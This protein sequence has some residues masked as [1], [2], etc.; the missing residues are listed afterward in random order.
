[1]KIQIFSLVKKIIT[2]FRLKFQKGQVC[3]RFFRREGVL[4]LT[5][6]PSPPPPIARRISSQVT[7]IGIY[8]HRKLYMLV[9]KFQNE[10]LKLILNRKYSHVTV[11]QSSRQNHLLSSFLWTE[12]NW[13][14]LKSKKISFI[15]WWVFIKVR[16]LQPKVNFRLSV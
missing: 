12:C 4:P 16:F 9:Y 14:P 3:H 13:V 11:Y 7:C 6:S 10:I 15:F 8:R 5:P 2:D 1:M